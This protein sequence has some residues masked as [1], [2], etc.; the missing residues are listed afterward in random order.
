MRRWSALTCLV[1]LVSMGFLRAQEKPVLS[2]V[3][4]LVSGNS[5]DET[6][7]ADVTV[8]LK[9]DRLMDQDVDPIVKFG[10]ET[11]YDLTVPKGQG[12][13]SGTLWQGFFTVS[14]ENPETGDGEYFFQIYAAID[15]SGA[16]MDTT[17]SNKTLFICRSG[18]LSLNTASLNFGTI[19]LG[20]PDVLSIV[21][22]NES[23]ADLQVNNIFVPSPFALIN[24]VPNFTIAGNGSRTL[25]IRF[26]PGTRRS[27]SE[28]MTIF[29]DDRTQSEHTIQLTGSAKGPRLLLNPSSSLNFGNVEVGDDSSR[30]VQIINEAAGNPALSETL[31][32]SNISTNHSV[33]T[34][35]PQ[36]LSI[37]PGDTETVAVTFTP[38]DYVNYS[39]RQAFFENN[40]LTQPNRPLTLNGTASDQSPPPS[41]VNLSATWSG[42]FGFTRSNFLP[43]CWDNP[44]DPSGIAE[45]W[46]KFVTSA[47]PPESGCLVDS[48]AGSGIVMFGWWMATAIQAIKMRLKHRLFTI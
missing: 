17:L 47:E 26:S 1:M 34:V 43:V 48:A 25:Q 18:E 30:T 22:N 12:W 9:F 31:N 8:Q 7:N 21:V 3:K 2:E 40:D 42:A 37:A 4:F 16:E 29:S 19:T 38:T 39:G 35:M 32:I 6:S 11:P 44:N 27:Y 24:S 28:T 33:Y 13:I 10:L 20:E 14:D 5:V 45:I 46:W 36:A 15:T 23:C 41:V